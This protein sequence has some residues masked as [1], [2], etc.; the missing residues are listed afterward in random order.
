[1]KSLPNCKSHV[2]DLFKNH[3]VLDVQPKKT[4]DLRRS[5]EFFCLFEFFT[6]INW[7]IDSFKN[8]RIVKM[9]LD[10][11]FLAVNP[12]DFVRQIPGTSNYACKV[13]GYN[14]QRKGD[15]I[16]HAIAKHTNIRFPCQYCDKICKVEGARVAHY[17]RVHKMDVSAAQIRAMFA[18][19]EDDL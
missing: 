3:A 17:K 6:N 13:C 7:L 5:L 10:F 8:G 14:T 16:K 12:L 18:Q 1:M 19:E 4:R 11:L 15:V 2:E 9:T